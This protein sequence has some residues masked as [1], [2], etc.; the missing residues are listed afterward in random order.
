MVIKL[1]LYVDIRFIV[2]SCIYLGHSGNIVL[3][4]DLQFENKS[5]RK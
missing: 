5:G 1:L 2:L 4:P 3:I